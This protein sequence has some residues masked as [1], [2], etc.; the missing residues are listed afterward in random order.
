MKAVMKAMI[1]VGILLAAGTAAI[2][3]NIPPQTK[4]IGTGLGGASMEAEVFDSQTKTQLGAIVQSQL[5]NRVS[6][7]GISTWGDAK[8]VMDD[9]AVKFRERLDEIHGR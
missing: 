2:A 9:W 5:G 1:G 6:L 3:Q 4:L 8:A 7:D